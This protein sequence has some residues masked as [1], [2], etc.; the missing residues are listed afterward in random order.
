MGLFSEARM[1]ARKEAGLERSKS[2]EVAVQR[3]GGAVGRADAFLKEPLRDKAVRLVGGEFGVSE[4]LRSGGKKTGSFLRKTAMVAN[5]V[6]SKLT[7]A[8]KRFDQRAA[9]F[10]QQNSQVLS[11]GVEPTKGGMLMRSIRGEK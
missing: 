11:K 10:D 1:K 9:E 6:S 3:I 4:R 8:G 7:R 2:A 5:K